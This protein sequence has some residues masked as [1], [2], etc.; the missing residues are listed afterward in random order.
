M[1]EEDS[2]VSLRT[3]PNVFRHKFVQFGIAAIVAVG[4]ASASVVGIYGGIDTGVG[5]GGPW[6]NSTAA[7]A[8]FW[9]ALSV[10]SPT[11]TFEG[12]GSLSS[13]GSGVSATLV[14]ADPMS[15]LHTQNEHPSA[16]GEY[17]GYNVTSG[18]NEWLMVVPQWGTPTAPNPGATLTFSFSSG[19]TGFGLWFTDTQVDFPGPITVSFN[20]GAPEQLTVTKT[21]DTGGAAY[22]GFTTN[23]PF[24]S[25]SISTGPISGTTGAERDSWGVD[26]ITIGTA[27]IELSPEPSTLSLLAL[28]VL[29]VI[30]LKFRG[31]DVRCALRISNSSAGRDR[32]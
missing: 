6:P 10:S 4:S 13:L 27:A 20:D 22:F 2:A 12:V 11:I 32:N 24:T 8:A 3:L 5:P 9:A 14:N 25:V 28:A 31:A 29:L 17:L 1:P 30:C 18:G 26:N 19:I 16:A 23:A 7:Q 15:G 21:G